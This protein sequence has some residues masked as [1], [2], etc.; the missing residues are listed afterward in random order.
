[1]PSGKKIYLDQTKI[2]EIIND[3]NNLQLSARQI[4]KKYN[5]KCQK[6]ILSI[7]RKNNIIIRQHKQSK[8]V[9]INENNII[10]QYN[11]PEITLLQLSKINKINPGTLK[12]ILIKHNVYNP[13]KYDEYLIS[14]FH[15]IDCEEK[16]YWLG[17]MIADA[18][19]TNKQLVLQL[20]Q[21]DLEHIINFKNFINTNI[22][23][24]SKLTKLNGK[25]YKS[26]RCSISSK[27]F[28]NSLLKYNIYPNKSLTTSIP[29]TIPSQYINHYIRGIF[30]GDGSI[31]FNRNKLHFSIISSCKLAKQIQNILVKSCKLNY[32]K[33]Y[34]RISKTNKKYC[35]LKYCGN[36]Q[37]K[38]IYSFLYQ[39]A[40]IFLKRKKNIF[41]KLFYQIL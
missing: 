36:K 35:Y 37:I 4:A 22:K 28:V 5:I 18:Y 13:N 14:K 11:S 25:E 31:H 9:N 34:T 12:K 10:S 21:K 19:V 27:K 24:Y 23:I 40:N 39:N 32:T 6:T 3:Y 16:A 8:Y 29:K 33:L 41:D 15:I 2:N 20:A 38:K 7:L 17:F 26:Y 1:M 30:D